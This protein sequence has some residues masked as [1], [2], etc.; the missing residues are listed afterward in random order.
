MTAKVPRWSDSIRLDMDVLQ[1]TMQTEFPGNLA[2]TLVPTAALRTGGC[3]I[4]PAGA[5]VDG[6]CICAGAEPL[7]NSAW[8]VT[9]G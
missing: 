9:L 6:D 7:P 4:E 5:V 2:L 3:R 8:I 1:D